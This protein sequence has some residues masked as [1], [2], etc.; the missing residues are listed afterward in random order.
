MKKTTKHNANKGENS[1]FSFSKYQTIGSPDAESDHNLDK[2]F[3]ENGELEVLE[4]LDNAKC[5]ITG[6]TGAGK[7][8]LLRVFQE[9]NKTYTKRISPEEMSLKYISNSDILNYFRNIGVNI[10]FFYKILWKH[11]FV[12]EILKLYMSDDSKRRE[13]FIEKVKS[14]WSK[15]NP[16]REKSIAYL[17]KWSEQFW[18]R[19]EYRVKELE[20][21]AGKE[22]VAEAGFNSDFFKFGA[23]SRD[24]QHTKV[25]TELKT[26]AERVI[27]SLQATELVEVINMMKDNLLHTQQRK[28][29]IIIDDLDKEWVSTQIVYDLIGAMVEVIKEFQFFKSVKIII[30]LR[31]NLHQLVFAG[32]EHRGGQREKFEHLYINLCWESSALYKLLNERIKLLSN[33]QLN[34]S[35]VFPKSEKG[36]VAGFSYILD[37]T[38]MRPRDVISFVNKIITKSNSKHYFEQTLVKAAEPEYSSER[39]RAI[40]DEWSENFGDIRHIWPA[41]ANVYNG[42]KMSN[43]NEDRL[44]D[45]FVNSDIIKLFKGDLNDIFVKWTTSNAPDH[46]KKSFLPKFFYLLYT[47]GIIGIKKNSMESVKFFYMLDSFVIKQDFTSEARIYIHKTFYHS[48]KIMT[49]SLENNNYD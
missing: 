32:T 20:Q 39:L 28:F 2:V 24:S 16:A 40:E 46:Y 36:Q 3:I 27:S 11:V 30:A 42:F 6:R 4:D 15:K 47:M 34:I 19:A 1:K 48:L 37:R 41:F 12:V 7:S 29:Y 31:D 8:A 25:T 22:F 43:F 44:A 26:K 33:D 38:F 18:E 49:K 35:N 21:Q 23:N 10:N 45:I 14:T 5:I 13:A 17:E 9:R